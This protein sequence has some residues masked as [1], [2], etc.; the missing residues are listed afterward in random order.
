MPV[1][2]LGVKDIIVCGHYGCSGVQAALE[3]KEL[4]LAT[5]WLRHLVDVRDNF[6]NALDAVPALQERAQLLCALKVVEKVR[7]VSEHHL[8]AGV[9]ETAGAGR[10]RLGA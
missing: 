5:N 8:P 9:G 10:P 6:P 7:H 3:G 4:G 2:V 1:E